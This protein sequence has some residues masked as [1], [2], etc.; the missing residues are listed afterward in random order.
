MGEGDST[1][2]VFDS[3]PRAVEAVLAAHRALA[4]EEWPAG[5]RI[6]VRWGIHT[7]EAGRRNADYFGPTLLLGARLRAQADGGQVF[8]SSVTSELVGTQ[9]PDGC[10][11]VDLGPHRLKGVGALERI[12][13]LKAPGVDTPP[14]VT[15]SPY[16]G[17][18]A[19]EASDHRFFFGRE[20]V[21]AD[22]S[23]RLVPGRL[24]AVVGASGS[25]KSSVL[26]AGLIAAARAGEVAGIDDA[27]LITP[28]AE[29]ELAVP[30]AARRLLV[31]DQF[32]ELFTL[33]ADGARR[34]RFIDALLELG[35]PVAIG[36]RADLY[37]RLSGHAELARAVAG[38]QVLLG[39]MAATGLERVVK[40]PARLAGL[41]LEPGLVELVLR[42]VAAEPG[43]LPLLS[44]ALRATWERRDGRTLTVDGYRASGGV[45]SAIARTAD[46][47]ID[48]LPADQRPLARSMFLRMTELG[49]GSE[50]SRRR[51]A[52]GELVPAGGSPD[53]VRALLE[54]LADARLVTLDDRTAEVA[55]E[56]LIRAWPRLR[57]WLEEDRAGIRAHRQLGDAARLWDAGGRETSDLYRGARLAGA[58]ELAQ[59]GRAELNAIE[60]AFLDAGV[61]EDDR[62]RRAQQ[63]A[64]RRLRGLLVGAAVLL[65]LAIAAGVL[66]LS[67]RDKAQQAEAAAER[68]ALASDAQR[69]GALARSGRSLEQSMLFAVA[70][71]ELDDRLDT[72]GDLLAVLQRNPA[73]I[74]TL[75]LPST[76]MTALATSPG[77]ALLASGDETGT[78]QFV[79]LETWTPAGAPV[80]LSGPVGVQAMQ[81]A[82]DG[83]T[84][85][86]GTQKGERY[87]VGV[88]DVATRRARPVWSRDGLIADAFL[89]TI[90]LAY[91]PGGHRLAV[92]VTRMSAT[93]GPVGQR[94]LL[95]EARSGRLLWERRIRMRPFQA[96]TYV[97]FAPDGR[98]ITSTAG[99]ETI[100]WDARRGRSVRRFPI[101]GPPAL[102]PDGN[103]LAIA[104][105][106]MDQATPSSAVAMLDLR[107]GRRSTLAEKLPDEFLEHVVFTPDG[108]RILGSSSEG[109]H[110]WDVASGAITENFG[111]NV[112]GTRLGVALGRRGSVITG[113][114]VGALAAWDLDGG[115]RLGRRFEWGTDDSGCPGIPCT[116]I[117]PNEPLMATTQP[118]GAVA[119]VDL[120]SGRLVHTLPAR[121]G[122][123]AIGIAFTSD[124]RRL[125]TGGIAGTVTIWD[126]ATRAVVRR[127]RF[128]APV[129]ATAISPDGRLLAVIRH[130]AGERDARVEVRALVSGATLY[131]R[132]VRGGA[133]DL[134]FSEDGRAL[135][136]SGCCRGGSTV[137][138]WNARTG[139]RRFERTQ[140]DHLT[141]FALLPGS[142]A[143]LVGDEDG[144]VALWDARTGRQVGAGT[145]VAG[146]G[147]A[148][149]AVSPDG[150]LFAIGAFDGSATLWDLRSRKRIG[151]EFAVEPG[152]VP[153][154]A[155]EPSG[156]LLITELG[157]AIAWPLDRPTLQRFACRIAGR[158]LTRE[159]WA[160]LLPA[161][162]YRHVC[163]A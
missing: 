28:G 48:G 133:G 12:F 138:A 158:D 109:T 86:V 40:E 159:E 113:A 103:T 76:G 19:F 153:A 38:N 96:E 141:A 43:A 30:D 135:F 50:G 73:A 46:A 151:D 122:P 107:S 98:L 35:C 149:I 62:E 85:A 61:A 93:S 83:R 18:L 81:F 136:A 130:A 160:D 150:R 115:Q 54:R 59:S 51:V 148:Q 140:D 157:S 27:V 26:R 75:H 42:D 142:H 4:A 58:V 64:N 121:N 60:R 114:G 124:G 5:L 52:V 45:A 144:A 87:E 146:G 82:P 6:A 23:R 88:V 56:A 118:G 63:R 9:L 127:L 89:P 137:A 14:P 132:T 78:V 126:V 71:V 22:L 94:L 68:Q 67:Q 154:V 13:A 25:G 143:L 123:L 90:T 111:G 49:D 7:G 79:D 29:P 92:A 104:R 44:H 53:A 106:R 152:L 80:R 47:V 161:R 72:R 77:G 33:C 3:A 147:V 24:L 15:E 31:V 41:K 65:V 156:G 108:S 37:G 105:S 66:S 120:R 16:R 117:A 91:A 21:V 163:P 32:E 131:T 74:R 101:G 39:T 155:F 1:V 10:S 116:V 110:V 119:L 134:R 102:A 145:R 99:G 128:A 129:Y 2:S 8:L 55:H 70:G 69:V 125:V 95:L 20:A 162:P 11:L 84:L 17:L 112:G 34:E 36:M 139:A 100:V 57:R 97:R